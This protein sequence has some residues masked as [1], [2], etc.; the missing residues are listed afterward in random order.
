MFSLVVIPD[1]LMWDTCCQPRLLPVI[2]LQSVCR[3]Y[4]VH[5]VLL[6]MGSCK[7]PM[8]DESLH[9]LEGDGQ[10]DRAIGQKWFCTFGEGFYDAADFSQLLE[11]AVNMDD[12]SSDEDPNASTRGQAITCQCCPLN[13]LCQ[14]HQ[15]EQDTVTHCS[16]SVRGKQSDREYNFCVSCVGTDEHGEGELEPGEQ[17]G[18]AMTEKLF[19]IIKS[20]FRVCLNW[21]RASVPFPSCQNS[22]L[23]HTVEN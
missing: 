19:R 2:V 7:K 14:W 17:T 23:K 13:P 8:Q 3:V 21:N 12:N 20:R 6:E 11:S 22:K 4:E 5:W 16:L 9:T 18:P 15:I 1:S 10:L